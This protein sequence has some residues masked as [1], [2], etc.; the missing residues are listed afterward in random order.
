MGK[1]YYRNIRNGR[2]QTSRG[3]KTLTNNTK[4]PRKN[5]TLQTIF[6][7]ILIAGIIFG[8]WFGS[9]LILNTKIPPALAVISESMC[10]PYDGPCDGYSH[11]FDRTVHIGD[12]IVIQGVDPKTLNTNYP[13]SDIIVFHNPQ[14]LDELIVHRIVK[15]QEINGTLYFFTKGDGNNAPNVWPNPP[16]INDQWRSTDPNIPLGAVNESLIEGKVIMRVPWV[17]LIAISMREVFGTNT[18][19]IVVPVL[20]V[21]IILLAIAEFILPILKKKPKKAQP[22]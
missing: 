7:V 9:Q 18:F 13:N 2:E 19:S 16:T 8:F 1:F 3:S 17:G 10:I 4:R 22:T 14:N 21:L 6:A 12:L 11:P 5:D 15:T 20:V